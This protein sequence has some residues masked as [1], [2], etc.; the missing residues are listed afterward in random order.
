MAGRIR[1]VGPTRLDTAETQLAVRR[2]IDCVA[3]Y[4]VSDGGPRN[5]TVAIRHSTPAWANRIWAGLC[6][7][8]KTDGGSSPSCPPLHRADRWLSL[9]RVQRGLNRASFPAN[10][11]ALRTRKPAGIVTSR[12]RT[13][14]T[15]THSSMSYRLDQLVED[16]RNRRDLKT[17]TRIAVR[18][19]ERNP[20]NIGVSDRRATNRVARSRPNH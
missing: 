11:T 6:L 13:Q 9:A 14:L 19:C 17:S 10:C 2:G 5:A 16:L 7:P 1:R 8:P 4:H 20:A 3:D 15:R 18:N 12:D